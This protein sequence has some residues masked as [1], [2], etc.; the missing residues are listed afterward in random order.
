MCG[1][2][3]RK[4]AEDLKGVPGGGARRYLEQQM[5]MLQNRFTEIQSHTSHL[6]TLNWKSGHLKSRLWI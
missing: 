6:A 3:M 4:L 1:D 5:T 2:E